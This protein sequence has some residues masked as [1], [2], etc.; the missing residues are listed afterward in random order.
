MPPAIRNGPNEVDR[1]HRR[2]L[3]ENAEQE[4]RDDR[5]HEERP[6]NLRREQERTRGR[7]GQL[8]Q[9]NCTSSMVRP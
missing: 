6:R 7:V 4:V 2:E 1:D 8:A 5:E 3:V 9:A